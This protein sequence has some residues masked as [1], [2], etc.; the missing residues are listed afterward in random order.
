MVMLAANE[1]DDE[2]LL[3]KLPFV[4]PDEIPTILARRG[5]AEL[6]TVT[7]EE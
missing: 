3:K 6:E 7:T 4:T 5:A 1:L 2:T